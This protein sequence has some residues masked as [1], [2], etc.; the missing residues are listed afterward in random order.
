MRSSN[1]A[2]SED[3]AAAQ[4]IAS[5]PVIDLRGMGAV[6]A[7]RRRALGLSQTALGLKAELSRMPVYRLEAGRDVALSSLLAMLAVLEI[8][9]TLAPLQQGPLRAA[10]LVRAFAHLHIDDQFDVDQDDTP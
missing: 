1:S 8:G 6:V 2:S 7:E 3:F 5:Q 10:D 4:P 9:L